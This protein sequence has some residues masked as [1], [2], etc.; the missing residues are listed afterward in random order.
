MP[1]R[2]LLEG[3]PGVGKTTVLRRCVEQLRSSGVVVAGFVTE[4]LRERGR[5]VGFAVE[6]VGGERGVLA[7]V[8][9][10]GPPR[11]GRYGVDLASFE[12]IALPALEAPG[13]VVVADELGKMELASPAFRA[14]VT[15]LFDGDRPVLAT[16]HAFRH[17]FTDDLKRRPDVALVRVTES[18][19]DALPGDLAARLLGALGR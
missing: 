8:D 1:P 6:R 11:V 15:G 4:E 17:P 12:R 5:R 19:R 16:V 13:E 7:H 2:I 14:A 18:S 3:R 10:P 9:L